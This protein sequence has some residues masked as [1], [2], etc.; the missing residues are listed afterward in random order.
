MKAGLSMLCVCTMPQIVNQKEKGPDG[1]M[2]DVLQMGR[3]I[4][5]EPLRKSV[6]LTEAGMLRALRCISE[7]PF[8]L[9]AP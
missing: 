5:M 3:D 4:E 1:R 6:S 8:C 9:L 7:P 2:H